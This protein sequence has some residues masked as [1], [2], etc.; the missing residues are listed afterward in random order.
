MAFK[1]QIL[2]T[3]GKEGSNPHPK[4]FGLISKCPTPGRHSGSS[5]PGLQNQ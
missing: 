1:I 3:E 5:Y 4:N 2:E